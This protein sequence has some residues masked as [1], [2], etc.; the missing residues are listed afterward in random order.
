MRRSFLFSLNKRMAKRSYGMTRR[1]TSA[2]LASS[3]SSSRVSDVR[4]A[5]SRRKSSRSPRSRNRTAGLTRD[6]A[7]SAWLHLHSF[8]DNFDARAGADS[9]CPGSHHGFQIGQRFDASRSFH[10]HGFSHRP[11]HQDDVSHGRA[12]LAEASRGLH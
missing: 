8:P 11:A 2:T 12:R 5:T 7:M 9:R 10:A 3:S 4:V 6:T 1:T